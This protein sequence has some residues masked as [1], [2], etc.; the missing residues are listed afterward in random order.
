VRTRRFLTAACVSLLLHA[1]LISGAW[2]RIPDKIAISRPLEARLVSTPPPVPAF[3]TKPPKPRPESTE[4][5]R[6]PNSGSPV[7]AVAAATPFAL[8]TAPQTPAII[9]QA[10][11]EPPTAEPTLEPAP[12]PSPPA[13]VTPPAQVRSL[14]RKGRITYAL[15]LGMDNF[16]VGKATQSW[17]V[18]ADTYLLASEA[19]T[20]G[21]V[22][23]F[24]PQRLRSLSQGKLT[25][26]GLQPE[27]FL[28]SRTRRGQTEAAQAHFDW[29]SGNL[30]FG[31]IRTPRSAAL[32]AGS[33][34]LISFIYQ[35]SLM[36]PQPGR[37]RVP[38]TNGSRFETYDVEVS[39]QEDIATPLGMLRAVP[40]KQVRRAGA[41]SIE[42][43]LAAE[44]RYL[45]VKIRF[46]DR[47]GNPAGEQIVNEIHI[48]EE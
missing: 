17:E 44:Y 40:V 22:D 48:S 36:P 24:R 5:R 25:P 35:M 2:L 43:W 13:A 16:S 38:V 12:E 7:P 18:E 15:Y 9:A 45:P 28:T 20:T 26:Q 47:E 14:P 1:V 27:K 37:F 34:D 10:E 3:A 19:E 32:P 8:P 29:N 42:I 33:Q 4:P 11:P 6:N 31:N 21:I 23:F 30:T 46:L 41:E 39:G